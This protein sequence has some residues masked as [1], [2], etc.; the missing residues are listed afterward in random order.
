[1]F[2]QLQVR[3]FFCSNPDCQRRIFTERLP[4]VV[5]PWGRKT[6]RMAQRQTYIGL[7]L[8]GA[9]GARLSGCL[10][11]STSRHT[12]LRL[13]AQISLAEGKTPLA[14][15]V[16]DWAYRKG[17]KYGTILVNLQ[18]HQPIALL[19]DRESQTLTKWLKAHPGVVVI[20][21]DRSRAYEKGAQ[22]LVLLNFLKGK[23]VVTVEVV[24]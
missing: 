18:T 20:S 1:M 13:V 15:G 11:Y 19:P 12:L 3:K 4:D 16:D 22:R 8:G 21:R 7:A 5:E 6:N 9:A 10:G 23:G 24:S 14:L 17:R 2:W